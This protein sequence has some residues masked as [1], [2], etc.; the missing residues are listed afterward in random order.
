[1]GLG[2][3]LVSELLS[4][5]AYCTEYDENTSN[6]KEE[7]ETL[8]NEIESLEPPLIFDPRRFV[9]LHSHSFFTCLFPT[10][11]AL[12]RSG[13]FFNIIPTPPGAIPD[14]YTA[15]TLLIGRDETPYR[16]QWGGTLG[17]MQQKYQNVIEEVEESCWKLFQDDTLDVS[18]KRIDQVETRLE[19][20]KGLLSG[21]CNEEGYGY[22][23]RMR[24]RKPAYLAYST[25]RQ[26]RRVRAEHAP[27]EGFQENRVITTTGELKRDVHCWIEVTSEKPFTVGHAFVDGDFQSWHLLGDHESWKGRIFCIYKDSSSRYLPPPMDS[28]R[29][30]LCSILDEQVI[31]GTLEDE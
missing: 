14:D 12:F 17:E 7:L 15:D 22:E 29:S 16:L 2:L 3:K 23:R 1:M 9:E 24:E 10:E 30:T 19:G 18:D 4:Y 27:K 6:K 21:H 26:G 20:L 11:Q 25:L 28:F 31:G 13:I 5:V 8:I